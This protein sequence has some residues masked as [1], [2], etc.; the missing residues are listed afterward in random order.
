M[1]PGVA[2]GRKSR[3]GVSTSATLSFWIVWGGS[4][5][6]EAGWEGA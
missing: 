4:A 2:L 3:R 5:S 1:R 6:S